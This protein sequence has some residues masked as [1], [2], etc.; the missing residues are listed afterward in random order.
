VNVQSLWSLCYAAVHDDYYA[1]LPENI[2]LYF[3]LQC[4]FSPPFL[5]FFSPSITSFLNMTVLHYKS[6]IQYNQQL[7]PTQWMQRLLIDNVN[8]VRRLRTT[9]TNRPT[10]YPPGDMWAWRAMVMP[11]GENSWLIHQSSLVTLPAETNHRNG[12]NSEI[13]CMF[14]IRDTSRDL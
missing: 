14:S 7:A 6:C 12:Q 2:Y 4:V 11:A 3:M 1:D 5:S 8:R 13:F 10:V 9:D